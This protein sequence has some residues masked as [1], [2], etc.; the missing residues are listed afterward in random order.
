MKMID[1]Y[2]TDLQLPKAVDQ[3]ALNKFMESYPNIEF[4]IRTVLFWPRHPEVLIDLHITNFKYQQGLFMR[5]VISYDV[6]ASA[7]DPTSY[8]IDFL[9]K[10]IQEI[11]EEAAK[12]VIT[13]DH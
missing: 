11:R 8:L 10:T 4:C 12:E 9:K 5:K 7:T 2:N 3:D 6:L 1:E 13:G